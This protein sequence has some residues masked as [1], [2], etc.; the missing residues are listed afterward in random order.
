[1]FCDGDFWHG[2]NLEERIRK[3]SVGHNAPYWIAKIQ[4][5]VAR[6]RRHDDELRA[7]GW[8]VLRYW[9]TD[10]RHDAA[11]RCLIFESQSILLGLAKFR[12]LRHHRDVLTESP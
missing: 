2:R 11:R 8:I 1:V 12:E 10:V 6:D 3:L 9:E 7:I 4:A 5:N